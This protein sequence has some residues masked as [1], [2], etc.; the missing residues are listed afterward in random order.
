MEFADCGVEQSEEC[1]E[2]LSIID[3]AGVREESEGGDET[4]KIGVNVFKEGEGKQGA[5]L[6]WGCGGKEIQEGECN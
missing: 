5:K 4:S 1:A 2:S 6:T 3:A